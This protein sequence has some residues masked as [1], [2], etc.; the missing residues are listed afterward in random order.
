MT[1]DAWHRIITV[2]VAHRHRPAAAQGSSTAPVCGISMRA[3]VDSRQPRRPQP[4]AKPSAR[5]R[6][7]LGPRRA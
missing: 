6:R 1:A 2:V 7:V 3:V 5:Q 4:G